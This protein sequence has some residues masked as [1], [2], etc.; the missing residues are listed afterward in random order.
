MSAISCHK[1]DQNKQQGYSDFIHPSLTAPKRP[2]LVCQQ[3][4]QRRA[5]ENYLS[6]K[7]YLNGFRLL[8]PVMRATLSKIFSYNRT[9]SFHT[10]FSKMNQLETSE[11]VHSQPEDGMEFG[12]PPDL[13]GTEILPFQLSPDKLPFHREGLNRSL[14]GFIN[15]DL[16]VKI[17]KQYSVPPSSIGTGNDLF[18][19]NLG[20]GNFEAMG[21]ERQVFKDLQNLPHINLIAGVVLED[22][23]NVLFFEHVKPIRT[24]WAAADTPRRHRWAIELASAV[25]H[26]EAAGIVPVKTCVDDIG[27]DSAGRLKLMGFGTSPRRLSRVQR[28]KSGKYTNRLLRRQEINQEDMKTAYQRLSACLHYIVSGIDPDEQAQK[29]DNDKNS[30]EQRLGFHGT[31]CYGQFPIS[32]EA[33]PISSI[34]Q[35]SWASGAGAQTLEALEEK[36]RG[37]LASTAEVIENSE[38]LSEIAEVRL[39]I[40]RRGREWLA[41]VTPEPRWLDH[42]QYEEKF[43]QAL[44]TCNQ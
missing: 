18:L 8:F 36:V 14:V 15:K 28:E 24:E 30:P 23:D 44:T 33:D 22:V 5:T 13:V 37:A 25:A 20:L 42:S 9:T 27:I 31:V 40:E 34:L 19:L 35:N 38:R 26:L 11:N 12:Q 39:A 16:V 41:V 29:T 4:G 3:K 1:E 2:I 43:E 6:Q 21:T 17:Q 7:D 10:P 32:P